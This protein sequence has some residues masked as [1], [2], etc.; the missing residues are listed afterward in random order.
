MSRGDQY[1]W[2]LECCP[3]NQMMKQTYEWFT[4]IVV[5]NDSKTTF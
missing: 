4:L 1:L 2:Q 5:K 3:Q